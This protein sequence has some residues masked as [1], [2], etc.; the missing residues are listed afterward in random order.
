M[1]VVISGAGGQLGRLAAGF[2]LER[3]PAAEVVLATRKPDELADFAARGVRVRRADFDEPDS[4]PEAFAGAQRLLLISTDAVGRRIP[5]HRNAIDA[6]VAAG[7]EHVAYTST[8]DPTPRNPAFVVEEHA[9][10]EA[11]LRDSGLA[12]TMLRMGN[13]SEFLVLSGAAAVASGRLEHNA[14]DG[15]VAY[16]SRVDCAAAAASVLMSDGHEGATYDVTGPELLTRVDLARLLGEVT[17]RPVEAV[18]ISDDEL[19]ARIVARGVPEG[20]AS[21]M[22]TWGSAIRAG[23]LAVVSSAVEELTGR[24]PRSVREVLTEHRDALLGG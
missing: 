11:A 21:R 6:A 15:K 8:L 17:G 19:V 12:W 5:Q 9:D 22:A 18:P 13:Y 20:L 24:P 7:I 1:T 4:L 10:T 2:L 16:V 3:L 23:V 14:G